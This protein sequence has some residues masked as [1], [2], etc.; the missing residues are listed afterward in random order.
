M[1]LAFFVL[2]RYRS[3]TDG[4]TDRHK[5]RALHSVAWVTRKP[6]N[7]YARQRRHS[8]MAVSRHLGYYRTGNR[9]IRSA[10]AENP[11]LEPN[12]EWIRCTVCEIFA[13]KL[14]IL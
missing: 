8:K 12:M 4:R 10:D 13:F 9:A 5:D 11:N 3:A 6:S 14:Y 7:G 1:T 2:I